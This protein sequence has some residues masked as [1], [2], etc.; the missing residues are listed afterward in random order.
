MLFNAHLE[1]DD[2][3][4]KLCAGIVAIPTHT[5]PEGRADDGTVYICQT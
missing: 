5:T 1:H 3:E 4:Y 2:V